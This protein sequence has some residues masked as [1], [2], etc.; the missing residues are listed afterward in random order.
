MSMNQAYQT[1]QNN[2]VNTATPAELTL[3]LYN[4]GIKFIKQAKKDLQEKNMEQKNINIQKAQKIVQ[5]FMITIDQKYE[6]SQNLMVM[7]D[8]MYRRLMEAN[9]NNDL[10]ILEEIEGYFVELRDT[11]KEVIKIN[12]QQK[13]QQ[14][15][16]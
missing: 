4:G 2:S 5:E 16:R 9:T 10:A 14:G 3:M 8:Y 7:Y 11:W 15:R 13:A 6:V 1:Y 12:K